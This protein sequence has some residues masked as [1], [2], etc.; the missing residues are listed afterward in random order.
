MLYSVSV[1]CIAFCV[2]TALTLEPVERPEYGGGY[3]PF[4]LKH[5]LKAIPATCKTI[6]VLDRTKEAGS[7]G[8]PLY[9]DVCSALIEAGKTDIKVVGGRYGLGSKELSAWAA[10]PGMR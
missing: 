5:F 1:L 7:L 6:A 8:E 10:M 4:S 2:Y 3:R 9:E